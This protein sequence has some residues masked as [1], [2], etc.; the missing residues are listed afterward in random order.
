[1]VESTQNRKDPFAQEKVNLMGKMAVIK[2]S[3]KEASAKFL[4]CNFNTMSEKKRNRATRAWERAQKE[5]EKG[6][7]DVDKRFAKIECM[8][9]LEE[10]V[11]AKAYIEVA[12]K[13][14]VA[15]TP[16][17]KDI[18]DEMKRLKLAQTHL[19]ESLPASKLDDSFTNE[20]RDLDLTKWPYGEAEEEGEAEGQAE[21]EAEGQAKEEGEAEEQAEEE[22]EA[23]GQAEEEGEAEGEAKADGEEEQ[24][25]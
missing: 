10:I 3:T 18:D 15:G 23:E 19:K 1:M 22:G 2:T 8:V 6:L 14:A 16:Y 9:A 12:Y 13:K 25:E 4:Q 20:A 11:E 21:E 24:K 17:I 5:A 7:K